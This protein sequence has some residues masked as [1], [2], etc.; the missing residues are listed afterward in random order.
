MKKT[1]TLNIKISDAEY[2]LVSGNARKCGRNMS[3]YVRELINGYVPN[4]L[5]PVEYRE[6]IDELHA[7]GEKLDDGEEKELLKTALISLIKAV[8][9]PVRRK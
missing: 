2:E 1:R 9:V 5:P 6:L 3:S 8:S 4:E 7:I